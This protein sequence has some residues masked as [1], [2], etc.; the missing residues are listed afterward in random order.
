MLEIEEGNR[1]DEGCRRG[2]SLMAGFVSFEMKAESTEQE[3]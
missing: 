2:S 1:R 3:V